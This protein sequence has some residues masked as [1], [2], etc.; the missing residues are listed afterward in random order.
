MSAIDIKTANS[1]GTE[2]DE[3]SLTMERNAQQPQ[4]PEDRNPLSPLHFL[5]YTWFL[6]LIA[7]LLGTDVYHNLYNIGNLR[8]PWIL[9]GGL[10]S[11]EIS[12]RVRRGRGKNKEKT[13]FYV[14]STK[15][16]MK[17][18]SSLPTFSYIL[19]G[20]SSTLINSN[21]MSNKDK[22]IIDGDDN[23]QIVL[24]STNDYTYALTAMNLLPDTKYFYGII[25]IDDKI[26]SE[27]GKKQQENPTDRENEKIFLQKHVIKKDEHYGSFRTPSPIK[28]KM[29]FTIA[30][31]GCSRTESHSRFYRQIY[32]F[33]DSD[34]EDVTRKPLL[35]LHLG[36]FHYE[37]ISKDDM[38][39]RISAID[40]VL[41]N[42]NQRYLYANVPLVYI[43]DDHD[44]LGN[45]AYGFS[46][47]V[48]SRETAL[49][50][51][52]IA[53]P[54]YEPLPAAVTKAFSE[55]INISITKN[56]EHAY[57]YPRS[58][59]VPPYQSFTIG[60]VRFIM[61][62]LRST[63][64][65]T[66]AYSDE[67]RQWFFE[68]MSNS[69]KYD[70][71]VWMN[72]KPWIGGYE[73]GDRWFN[74]P[75]ERKLLSDHIHNVVTKKNLIV[76]SADAHMLAFDDGRNTYYGS[77]EEQ[78][79]FPLLH[80]GPLH[81]FGS[82]KGG[83]YSHGC[84]PGYSLK[85]DNHHYSTL[86]FEF[87][88]EQYNDLNEEEEE[89]VDIETIDGCINIKSYS[90]TNGRKPE[91]VFSHQMCGSNIFYNNELKGIGKIN[92]ENEEEMRMSENTECRI[93]KFDPLNWIFFI[94]SCSA[95][96]GTLMVAPKVFR[97][98]GGGKSSSV[99]R[100]FIIS[101]VFLIFVFVFI[102]GYLYFEQRLLMYQ[103]LIVSLGIFP[104]AV[105]YTIERP[106][107][108]K[109]RSEL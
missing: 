3:K 103:V 65:E 29:N 53:F 73:E 43:W 71:V 26:E 13:F 89:E 64:S 1:S 56:E 28:Q 27:I 61:T 25:E 90:I 68:E 38:P 74:Y 57:L 84:F 93:T 100:N 24:K 32:D 69:H 17:T 81:N 54:H 78:G 59:A 16:I 83:P 63:S 106:P 101:L 87:P 6:L 39:L 42:R 99:F 94:L 52:Q 30:V 49:E 40:K 109:F 36:D 91:V 4:T 60:T 86:T 8:D 108:A 85:N 92:G 48:S 23:T 50:S 41:Q 98:E 22:N 75:E 37:D 9:M 47:G 58:T 104:I 10:K 96:F 15:N 62:D 45:N 66:E 14:M 51:Y 88:Q 102:C 44:W 21:I 82:I 70:Y 35:F 105:I 31:A 97:A 55:T 80:S 67:Q 95:Y 18:S 2:F 76:L 46:K 34:I 11:N 5:R 79:S 107:Y 72:T 33:D 77:S 7:I 19:L 20:S 12:F